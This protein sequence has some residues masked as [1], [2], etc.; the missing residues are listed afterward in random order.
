MKS[1]ALACPDY[2]L[3]WIYTGDPS[4]TLD[5]A[6]WLQ[7]TRELRKLG[8][9]VL[10]IV[11]GPPE[12][13]M[14]GDVE[15]LSL[16]QPNLYLLRQLIFHLNCWRYLL[17]HWSTTDCIMFHQMSAPWLLPLRLLRRLSGRRRPLLVMD[18]RTVHMEPQA[19]ESI[20]ARLRRLLYGSMGPL[21]NSF[22]DGQTAITPRM[23]TAVH[24]PEGQLWGTWPSGVDLTIF[25][26]SHAERCWPRPGEAIQLVYIGSLH[27]ERNLLPLCQA[28]EEVNRT[29]CSFTF[30]IAGDGTG[31]ADLADFAAKTEGRV[32]LLPPVPHRLVPTLLA[33]AHIGVLPF[34]DEQKFRVSSPIKLFEYMAAALPIL[35]TRIHCHTDVVQEGGYAF[36]A[37]DATMEGF[38]TAL[39]SIWSRQAELQEMGQQAAVAAR[40]WSWQNAA[41]RLRSALEYG[42]QRAD[43]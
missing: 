21:A 40:A 23:A 10:L 30:L 13:R 17:R 38:A 5:S 37:G 20:K 4:R 41:Q 15:V 25:A 32:Q 12:Q 33:Q 9:R 16:P 24:I 1:S 26:R 35:A 11:A 6:T 2:Q 39:R 14:I 18:T 3:I 36:W 42:L 28:V 27:H 8:W 34:P 43:K 19:N 31:R 7:T 29:G 22:A